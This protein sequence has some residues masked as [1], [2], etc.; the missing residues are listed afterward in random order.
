MT[1]RALVRARWCQT[2]RYGILQSFA[3]IAGVSL[4]PLQAP[5]PPSLRPSNRRPFACSSPR[6]EQ[7][8]PLTD[9]KILIDEAHYG[10]DASQP[11]SRSRPEAIVPWYLQENTSKKPVHPLG[12]RQRIPDLPPNPPPILEKLLQHISVDIGLDD[13]ALLDLRGLDPPPALGSK[14]IMIIGT[15]RSVKHLNVSA[16]RLCR[17]LRSTYKL[18]PYADGLLGRNELKLKLR[19]K[20]RRAK[21]LGSVGSSVTESSDDGITTGWVCVNIGEVESGVDDAK[22]QQ[23]EGFVGFGKSPGGVKIVV[24]LL[25]EEKRAELELESLWGHVLESGIDTDVGE[26]RSYEREPSPEIVREAPDISFPSADFGG[27]SLNIQL[28]GQR[29]GFQQRSYHTTRGLMAVDETEKNLEYEG[30]DPLTLEPE[31]SNKDTLQ[32]KPWS[33]ESADRVSRKTPEGVGDGYGNHVMLR[34]LMSYLE[35]RSRANAISQLGNGHWDRDSTTFLRNFYHLIADLPEEQHQDRLLYLY[36]LGVRFTHP[37]YPKD[38]LLKHLNEMR[39]SGHDIP[40]TSIFSVIR[41]LLAPVSN[42][43]SNS[44]GH[45]ALAEKVPLSNLDDSIGIVKDMNIRGLTSSMEE[46]FFMLHEGIASQYLGESDVGVEKIQHMQADDETISATCKAYDRLH[47]TM[48]VFGLQWSTDESYMKILQLHADVRH[49]DGFWRVWGEISLRF[50]RRSEELY[51]FMFHTVAR[52]G[53]QKLCIDALDRNLPMMGYEEPPVELAGQVAR[54]VIECLMI[55]D[56]E[57]GQSDFS[58]NTS[59]NKWARLYSRALER[60]QKD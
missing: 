25:T 55:I 56:P 49:W 38:V 18:R 21:L 8:P 44:D 50:R 7:Q 54:S 57:C 3:S 24:Q 13:L 29:G 52:S 23:P 39:M 27:R 41:A 46:I 51:S 30:L 1:A 48:S 6:S 58:D 26:Y 28:H 12:D 9:Y 22:E 11:A 2:C 16:D 35:D 32:P 10:T 19:R 15:A 45:R 5:H 20:A 43:E 60:L 59:L 33:N 36:A 47:H 37:G 40:E 53:H 31:L 4:G 14:L 34:S 17:W 42:D